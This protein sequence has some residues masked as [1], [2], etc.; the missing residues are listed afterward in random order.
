MPRA[1]D[2]SVPR[3]AHELLTAVMNFRAPI[4]ARFFLATFLATCFGEEDDEM[5]GEDDSEDEDDAAGGF[6]ELLMSQVIQ[7]FQQDNG[8]MP[9]EVELK[10]LEAAI[11]QKL[12]GISE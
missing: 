4:A 9:D 10:A 1:V 6:M 11:T 3:T 12:A 2:H 7:R 5:E 8:R